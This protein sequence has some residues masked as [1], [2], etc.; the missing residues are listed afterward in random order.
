M[1]YIDLLVG[2]NLEDDQGR[3][4]ARLADA[5]APS[6]VTPGAV[7]VAVAPRAWSWTVVESIHSGFVYFRQ[8]SA[9]DA[10]RSG[11]GAVVRAGAGRG[12]GALPLLVGRSAA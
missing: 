1:I 12:G 5:I 6:A 4:V 9:Q 3:N 7:L 8:I 10:A 11:H 2:L